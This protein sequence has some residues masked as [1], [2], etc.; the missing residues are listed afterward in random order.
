MSYGQEALTEQDPFQAY[1]RVMTAIGKRRSDNLS[2]GER[3]FALCSWLIGEV[4]NGGFDQYFFNGGVND[5]Y[6]A[7]RALES[8]GA[9]KAADLVRQAI[10]TAKVPDP[11]SP[12][13][14]YYEQAT[15]PV[16]TQLDALDKQFYSGPLDTKE[17]YPCLVRYLRE[18]VEE[19]A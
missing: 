13:Y 3:I 2:R 5:V 1:Y 9:L 19:F 11:P 15:E 12:Q 14:D 18:H 10:A 16:R 6:E 8:I 4:F 7:A 17:V